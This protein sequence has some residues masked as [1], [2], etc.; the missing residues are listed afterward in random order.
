MQP[1]TP[2]YRAAIQRTRDEQM[3]RYRQYRAAA[4]DCRERAVIARTEHERRHLMARADELA[5]RA[6]HEVA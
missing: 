3:R 2:E 1:G 5:A 4:H 6:Y